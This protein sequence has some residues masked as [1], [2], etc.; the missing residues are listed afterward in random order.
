MPFNGFTLGLFVLVLAAIGVSSWS[1][2][3]WQGPWRGAVMAPGAFVVF[4]IL[5]IVVDTARDP[6]SHNLW[7]TEVVVSSGVALAAV[8]A[9]KLARRYM[10]V[11]P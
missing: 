7:P 3:K 9:L 1:A 6:T 2:W 8:G 5:R 10:G 4:V 11:T